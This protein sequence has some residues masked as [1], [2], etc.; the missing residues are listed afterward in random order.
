M[1]EDYYALMLGN[2]ALAAVLL[3]LFWY[4][5]RVSLGLRGIAL[6]GASYLTYTA[7]SALLESA[8]LADADGAATQ[9]VF[10]A[11][12]CGSLLACA[13][14]A[15]LAW[16]VMRFV[17]QRGGRPLDYALMAACVGFALVAWFGFGGVQAHRAA[18][19][20]A[21][22]VALVL[23]VGYLERMGHAPYKL[24]ARLMMAAAVMLACLYA[25]DL[26]HALAGRYTPASDWINLD[27]TLWFMLNFCMLTLSSFRAAESLRHNALFDP[28]TDA[29][30]RRGLD[31]QLNGTGR[32]RNRSR[33]TAVIALD[34]DH[35][36]RINDQHGHPIG[37]QVLRRFSDAVRHSIRSDDLFARVGGEEFVVVAR[38]ASPTD[39]LAL[40]ERIRREIGQQHILDIAP[41]KVTVSAGVAAAA[42]AAEI[43]TLM[44][45]ADEAL[46]EA[47]RLGR[48]RVQLWRPVP[49]PVAQA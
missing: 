15:G 24:P 1:S 42:G 33:G 17:E 37:D 35:F 20:A 31:D 29:L 32:R 28:L 46:Y 40:A 48:D 25:R 45:C 47:K 12:G 7:G 13:G 22:V 44:Q 27:L 26:T 36:K 2:I 4:V 43:D 38:D 3:A 30:N 8:T 5:S 10:W 23:V 16:A 19:S 18:M 21:E 11:A 39:A 9:M 41:Q 14:V 49:E 6:W 34:L